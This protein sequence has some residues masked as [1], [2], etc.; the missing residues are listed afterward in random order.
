M[1]GGYID[2]VGYI[3]LY[4]IFTANMS[5]N[6]V[7]VGMY[8]GGAN[9]SELLRPACAIASYVFGLVFSRIIL[10]A[11]ARAG[12]R[13]IAAITLALE[14]VLLLM[15]A[16]V[17][18]PM[19]AGQFTDLYSPVY[20]LCVALLGFAMGTQTGT[21]THIGALTVYT[22]FVTGTLTKT[23]EAFTRALFWVW[24][25][26]RAGESDVVNRFF[27]QK[28]V[29]ETVFLGSVWSCYVLGAAAG[30]LTKSK[31]EIRAIY[32]PVAILMSLIVLDLARPISA[33]EARRQQG[34]PP[35]GETWREHS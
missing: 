10:E 18:P 32:L 7:H 2:A 14:A 33:Q 17:A 5:G 30:T 21:L 31:W 13:R 23:S 26:V 4:Q 25:S 9:F 3:A 20:F 6:S 27:R 11:A 8:L 15:F 24:D 16:Y 19:R 1:V 28:D 22:T 12:F 35:A 29:R 34:E